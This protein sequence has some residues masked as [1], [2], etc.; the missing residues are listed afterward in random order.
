[1][2]KVLITLLVVSLLPVS[3]CNTAMNSRYTKSGIYFD[4]IVSVDIYGAAKD[5]ADRILSE[6]MNLCDKY[7]QL[8]DES[9]Q[10]SDIYR[11]NTSGSDPVKVGHDTAVLLDKALDYSK[12]TG[13]RFDI[14]ID[15]V[16]DLWDFHGDN[17]CIPSH[18]LIA[19]ALKRVGYENITVDTVNDTVSIKGDASVDVGA[20]AKG[21]IADRIC[22][23]LSSCPIEGAIINMGGDLRLTGTKNGRD[24]F[25]I[26]I[27]DP[28]S[29]GS[30]MADLCLTD[31]AVA[32]SGTYERCFTIGD[33]RYHHILDTATGFPVDTD[34]ESVTVITDEAVSADCLCTVL[35]ILGSE[36]G[37]DLIEK[38]SDTEAYIIKTDGS[39][40]TSSGMGQ[41]IRQ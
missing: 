36:D 2:K 17:A 30:V 28:F 6:C 31:K 26:G 19:D 18:D 27:N 21:Y 16:S 5:D 23:Y 25:D 38:T 13:G 15:P 10:T 39:V 8:F 3:G 29:Q 40:M 37:L 12:L 4:T 14:T 34:V 7:Q 9:I 22:E 32:T 41:Y 20:V 1:M 11:I 24:R 35:I 33:R